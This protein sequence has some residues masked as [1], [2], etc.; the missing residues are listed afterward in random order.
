MLKIILSL[1]LTCSSFISFAMESPTKALKGEEYPFADLPIEALENVMIQDL[2]IDPDKSIVENFK[3]VI[4]QKIINIYKV[5]KYSDGLK[6]LI[7]KK[8]GELI[9]STYSK[10]KIK[11]ISIENLTSKNPKVDIAQ[12]LFNA[13]AKDLDIMD[14][15]DSNETPALNIATRENNFPLVKF[16]IDNGA[17]VNVTNKYGHTPLNNAALYGSL[18]TVKYLLD[19]GAD[20]NLYKETLHNAIL[21]QKDNF[22]KTKILIDHGADLK[23]RSFLVGTPLQIAKNKGKNDIALLIEAKMIEKGLLQ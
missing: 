13:G 17:N 11:Q 3:T 4:P 5:F 20:V 16:L 18:E 10:D 12:I 14:S 2:K 9:K 7:N 19:H 1:I 21:S 15:M 8:F 23:F 6:N 22:E